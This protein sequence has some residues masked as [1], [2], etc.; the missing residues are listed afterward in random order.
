[1]LLVVTENK[2][3]VFN[4]ITEFVELSKQIVKD[5]GKIKKIITNYIPTTPASVCPDCGSSLIYEEGC[6]KCHICGFAACG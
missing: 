3:F 4:N 5:Y 2:K 1:M 6:K